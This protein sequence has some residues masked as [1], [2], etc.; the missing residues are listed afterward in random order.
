M[1]GADGAG[2]MLQA[3]GLYASMW[4]AQ[5]QG[6]RAPVDEED[7]GDEEDAQAAASAAAAGGGGPTG[8]IGGNKSGR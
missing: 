5:N 3:G 4:Q 7:E 2:C 8:S 6:S 1:T